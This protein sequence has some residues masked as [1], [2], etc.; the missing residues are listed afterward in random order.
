MLPERGLSSPL[1]VDN[2]VLLPAPFAPTSATISPSNTSS[3]TS[4][5]TW[6]SPYATLT[7]R[8]ASNGS[9]IRLVSLRIALA[10]L[11]LDDRRVGRNFCRCALGDLFAVLEP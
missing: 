6:T 9:G 4:H 11:P 3:D 7:S 2:R 10:E 5:S 1:T 8:T